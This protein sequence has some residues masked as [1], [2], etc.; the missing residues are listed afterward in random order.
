ME[1]LLRAEGISKSY[2]AVK[3][4]HGVGLRVRPGEIIGLLGDNGAGKS[5]LIG[6]VSG[7]LRPDKGSI[8]FC[9]KGVR[10]R[11]TRDAF[12]AG[13]E[14]VSQGASLV[15]QLSVARNLFLGREPVRSLV[16]PVG[17]LDER[18]MRAQAAAL[19]GRLGLSDV[20]PR[21][22]V[23]E[24][25]GGQRQGVAIARALFFEARL[26]LLDEPTNNLGVD[27]VRRVVEFIRGVREKGASVVLVTHDLF[28][29]GQVADRFV[30]LRGG[31]VVGD[32]P[33]SGVS[34]EDIERV[35][36]GE[37]YSQRGS[38]D[39]DATFVA[40]GLVADSAQEG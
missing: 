16:G 18:Y 39:T 40:E 30:V 27:E 20:D 37:G 14:V 12:R 28:R 36:V 3:A 17:V 11:S 8:T 29:A 19:L 22:I 31:R 13:I 15:D 32:L 10:F 38:G 34:V 24:L 35:I 2:G 26:L 7:A 6:I 23:S 9:G 25:S 5:T 33:A 1:D 21:T 4:L